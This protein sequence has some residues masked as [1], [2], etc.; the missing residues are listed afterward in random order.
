VEL[1]AMTGLQTKKRSM[2]IAG[3]F[4]SVK[5]ELA[6][7]DALDRIAQLRQAPLNGLVSEIEQDRRVTMPD[8]SL[9]SAIRVYTLAHAPSAAPSVAS[10]L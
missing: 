3:K 2:R 6:F 8:A 7:W 1:T 5:L 10:A 9:A 4:T